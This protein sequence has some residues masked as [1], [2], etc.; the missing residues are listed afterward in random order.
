MAWPVTETFCTLLSWLCSN[1]SQCTSQ[2]YET[3]TVTP[4]ENGLTFLKETVIKT[5]LGV[6]VGNSVS[7]IWLNCGKLVF[8]IRSPMSDSKNERFPDFLVFGLFDNCNIGIVVYRINFTGRK[9]TLSLAPITKIAHPI[10]N[11]Q[12]LRLTEQQTN[13]VWHSNKRIINTMILIT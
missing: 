11:T 10:L 4:M 5:D 8:S 6:G 7:W 12:H 2:E 3:I 13:V 9:N 1:T